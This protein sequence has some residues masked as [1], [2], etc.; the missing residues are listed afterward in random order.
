MASFSR[1][2]LR[3][4]IQLYYTT[5]MVVIVGVLAVGFYQYEKR[6]R[7]QAIDN[8]LAAAKLP[9]LPRL[10]LA[11]FGRSVPHRAG[12]RPRLDQSRPPP[13]RLEAV[14]DLSTRRAFFADDTLYHR[15]TE[16][17]YITYL[18]ADGEVLFASENAPDDVEFEKYEPNAGALIHRWSRG[19]REVLHVAPHDLQVIFGM[20]TEAIAE[21][22]HNLAMLALFVS[23]GA[24]VV[25]TVAGWFLLDRGLRPIEAISRTAKKISEGDLQERI[26]TE[27]IQNEL[28]PLANLLNETFGRLDDSLQAQRRYNADASHEMRTPLSI[29]IADC[30]FA[31]KRERSPERYLKT[32]RICRET[33]EHMAIL[34]EDLN[35]LAKADASSLRLKKESH[36]LAEFLRE[37]A[38]MTEPLSEKKSITVSLELD[39]APSAFDPKLMR[40]VLVNLVGNAVNYNRENGHIT[41]RTGQ[42]GNQCYCEIE[43]DGVGI[44]PEDLPHIF[45]RFYRVDKARGHVVGKTGLGLA[46]TQSIVEAHGGTITARSEFG[47]GTCMRI[48]LPASEP[49]APK[50]VVE[51]ILGRRDQ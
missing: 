36:D 35:L 17:I 8:E 4:Q 5:L 3:W 19:R 10:N 9:L 49:A 30:D 23:V 16:R 1:H 45:D 44:A 2:S 22:L 27:H 20:S 40:Q 37:I 7:L 41:I 29:I 14:G 51:M 32:I 39:P 34:V 11:I 25:F 48:E 21:E 18:D 42:S 31:L 26:P 6:L 46:I 33:A 12:H 24:C 13:R 43:D 47:V 15:V 50:T 28:G 38:L